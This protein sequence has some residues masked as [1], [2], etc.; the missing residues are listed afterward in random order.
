LLH[1]ARGLRVTANMKRPGELKVGISHKSADPLVKGHTPGSPKFYDVGNELH[2]HSFSYVKPKSPSGEFKSAGDKLI[3]AAHE[4]DIRVI[5]AVVKGSA[6]DLESALCTVDG[7]KNTPLLIAC[8]RG[9]KEFVAEI[10]KAKAK[11]NHQDEL[12]HSA[13]MLAA[14]N[15]FVNIIQM[16]A[17][18]GAKLELTTTF[19]QTALMKAC[20]A[21]PTVSTN[22][23]GALALIEAKANPDAADKN[24][25][26]ALM[27]CAELNNITLAAKFV[28][29]G[30]SINAT[31][32]ENCT[33]LFYAAMSRNYS[34]VEFLVSKGASTE[35]KN[36]VG[37]SVMEL[38]SVREQKGGSDPKHRENLVLHTTNGRKLISGE[39]KLTIQQQRAASAGAVESKKWEEQKAK[40]A[41]RKARLKEKAKKSFMN[42]ATPATPAA[43]PISPDV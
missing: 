21:S 29:A 7:Y 42:P 3:V 35:A 5:A 36:K 43:T 12:G 25:K 14:S 20:Y 6:K 18:R 34:M 8:N 31:D 38:K 23:Q 39:A 13:L 40:D 27:I 17:K 11:V 30:V 26:T 9:H 2:N 22:E 28:D 10:L 32:N 1:S 19:G 4:G 15:G 16:L 33:A 37:E 41:A 24:G